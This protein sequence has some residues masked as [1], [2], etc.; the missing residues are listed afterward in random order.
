MRLSLWVLPRVEQLVLDQ[1]QRRRGGPI[2]DDFF[3]LLFVLR[4]KVELG[5]DAHDVAA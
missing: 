2:T 5:L 3:E 1:P 4:A